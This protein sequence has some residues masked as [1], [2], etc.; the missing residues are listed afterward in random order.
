M[1]E[2]HTTTPPEI[3]ETQEPLITERDILEGQTPEQL[4]QIIQDCYDRA[5]K[6]EAMARLA[7]KVYEGIT[8]EL[9]PGAK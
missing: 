4:E 8:G 6:F 7:T 3:Q 5:A 2:L 9:Y 1:E